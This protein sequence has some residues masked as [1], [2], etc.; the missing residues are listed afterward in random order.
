MSIDIW[1]SLLAGK[2]VSKITSLEIKTEAQKPIFCPYF[3]KTLKVIIAKK[4]TLKGIVATTL[5]LLT[6]IQVMIII[7]LRITTGI[8]LP[9][10]T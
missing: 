10:L 2:I 7:I 9:R 6:A 5:L 3:T 8:S 1:K 4:G